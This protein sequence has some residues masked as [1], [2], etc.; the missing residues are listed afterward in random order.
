VHERFERPLMSEPEAYD[1]RDEERRIEDDKREYSESVA[2]SDELLLVYGF[3]LD[4]A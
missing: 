1:Q 4:R 2:Y 3:L